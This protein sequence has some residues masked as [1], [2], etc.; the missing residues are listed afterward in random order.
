MDVLIEA[1]KLREIKMEKISEEMQCLVFSIVAFLLPFSIGHPQVVVGVVVNML[2]FMTAFNLK[3]YKTLPI[4]LLP[5]IAVLSRGLIFGQ[6]TYFLIYTIPFIWIGNLLLVFAF[7]YMHFKQNWNKYFS[8]LTSI[9]I[10]FTV[11]YLPTVMLI[12]SNVLP[13][14]FATSMGVLQI[15][16][17]IVGCALA[18][19]LQKMIKSKKYE[20]RHYN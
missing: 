3:G 13:D 17:A 15:Y 16:T 7:K 1:L 5:S 12:K 18:L 9:A 19:I 8:L 10:K 11:L 4:I 20:K 6:F 2:L 14:I